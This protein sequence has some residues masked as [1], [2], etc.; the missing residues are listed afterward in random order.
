MNDEEKEFIETTNLVY[1]ELGKFN[2]DFEQ[3]THYFKSCVKSILINNGLKDQIYADFFTEKLTAEPIKSIFQ[4]TM[5]HSYNSEN[6]KQRIKKMITLFSDLIE[7]RNVVTH[8][9]WAIGTTVG[10][11]VKPFIFGLKTRISGTGISQY[12]LSMELN[13]LKNINK[14]LDLFKTGM[15]ELS[16]HMRKKREHLTKFKFDKLE[17]LSFREELI[18][19][20]T[21]RN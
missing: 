10:E 7:I 14:K 20:K 11:P 19:M 18:K 1:T 17:N 3:T 12:N 13:E 15:Y 21:D 9:Y 5:N 16:R 4:S 6:D 8:C 2:V